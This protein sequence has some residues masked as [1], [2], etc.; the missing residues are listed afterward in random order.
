M[1]TADL[2]VRRALRRKLQETPAFKQTCLEA[3]YSRLFA[4]V[5]GALP[6]FTHP[7][8]QHRM[9]ALVLDLMIR[10]IT[11]SQALAR[12]MAAL[13]QKHREK[14]I[15]PLHLKAG[16]EAF[17]A[18]VQTGCPALTSQEVAIFADLYD[19]M[20]DA[21]ADRARSDRPTVD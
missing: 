20:T 9:F 4:A 8:R 12:E 3:F 7:E 14:G 6:L 13:G 17:I 16:R 21:M 5:P 19:Q 11:D 10:D 2:E 18:A 1:R 15:Q